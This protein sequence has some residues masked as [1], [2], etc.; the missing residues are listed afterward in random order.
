[1][2]NI[3]GI[4]CGIVYLLGTEGPGEIGCREKR[5]LKAHSIRSI[6][7]KPQE[8]YLVVFL[9]AVANVVRN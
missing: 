5:A 3:K 6:G 1:M 2:I 8:M 7:W 9:R 4:Q